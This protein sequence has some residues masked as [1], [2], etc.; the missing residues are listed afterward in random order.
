MTLT[1]SQREVLKDDIQEMS[2]NLGQV[3]LIDNMLSSNWKTVD[4]LL[5]F[6]K[7]WKTKLDKDT[8]KINSRYEGLK[9]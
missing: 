7:V 6:I 2:F 9:K 3:T 8:D 1:E 5:M 4:E